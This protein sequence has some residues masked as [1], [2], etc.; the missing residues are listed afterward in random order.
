MRILYIYK[1]YK[2]RRKLY[3]KMME[4]LGHKVDYLFIEHKT[5]SNQIHIDHI[6]R[7]KPDLIWLLNPFYISCKGINSDTMN[8]IK[9]KKI[10]IA[11]ACTFDTRYPYMEWVDKVWRKIDFL[12]VHYKQMAEDLRALDINAHYMPLGFYPSQ[13]SKKRSVKDIDVSFMGNA[14]T[15][16]PKEQDK[17]CIYLESLKDFN[18]RIY[19]KSFIKRLKDINVEEY[20]GHQKQRQ[21]YARTKVNLSLPFINSPHP[22]YFD[23]YHQKNRLYEIPATGNFLLTVRNQ[24]FLDL[25]GEDTIGFYDDNI[26]SLRENV[27]RYIKDKTTREEMAKRAYKLVHQKYTYQHAFNKM[28]KIIES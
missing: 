5:K 12:F 9:S 7:Y 13:Y 24:E 11:M 23:K 19:G 10:P 16:L 14:I 21:V 15:C 20:N 6:K 1:E 27:S 26:E 25:F 3:G 4:N 8:F 22:F 18:I 28:F 17:R 2:D